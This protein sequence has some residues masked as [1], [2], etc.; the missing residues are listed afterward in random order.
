MK[1]DVFGDLRDWG[2]VL[3]VLR[4]LEEK[5]KLDEVQEGLIR[6]INYRPNW[7]LREKA[8]L[9]ARRVNRPSDPLLLA[10]LEVIGDRTTYLDARIFAS[11]TLTEL[12]PRALERSGN[13]A[14]KGA[15]LCRLSALLGAAE[16]PVL[17]E[18]IQ[19]AMRTVDFLDVEAQ[20]KTG[21]RAS[22]GE[23]LWS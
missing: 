6:L 9:S 17:S 20:P 1:S 12:A 14:L 5:G 3:A 11:Q 13:A 23:R 4:L 2:R 22:E 21:K 15:I 18:A 10:V 7:Q 8:L 19:K 16:P